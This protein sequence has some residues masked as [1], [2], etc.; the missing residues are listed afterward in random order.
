[1]AES[2]D[3]LKDG[4]S[5]EDKE[6]ESEQFNLKTIIKEEDKLRNVKGQK[7]TSK[8]GTITEQK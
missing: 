3:A 7:H 1:L 8:L 2:L 4:H 6:L 5:V